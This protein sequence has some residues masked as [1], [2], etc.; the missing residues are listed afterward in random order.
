MIDQSEAEGLTTA[1]N[2]QR[3]TN[4]V[5]L[6]KRVILHSVHHTSESDFNKWKTDMMTLIQTID[7][8]Q[9]SHNLVTGCVEESTMTFVKL[10]YHTNTS[11]LLYEIQQSSTSSRMKQMKRK[12]DSLT[13]SEVV[14]VIVKIRALAKDMAK[15]NLTATDQASKIYPSPEIITKPVVWE[16]YI[17]KIVNMQKLF[18]EISSDMEIA[19]VKSLVKNFNTIDNKYHGNRMLKTFHS[20]ICQ[21]NWLESGAITIKNFLGR[22]QEVQSM[23]SQTIALAQTMGFSDTGEKNN[24]FKGSQNTKGKPFKSISNETLQKKTSAGPEKDYGTA[25]LLDSVL[26]N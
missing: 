1:K 15:A 24:S 19:V 6:S 12:F 3:T 2:E 18:G 23:L 13:G 17:M 20:Y 16:T 11:L 14:E 21:E 5:V 4:A 8:V 9:K 22:A 25:K 26:S 10:Q 7:D